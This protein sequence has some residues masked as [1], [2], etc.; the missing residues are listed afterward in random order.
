MCVCVW[1]DLWP[2]KK[3]SR[4]LSLYAA[5]LQV[6][7]AILL[8]YVILKEDQGPIAL[9]TAITLFILLILLVTLLVYGIWKQHKKILKSYFVLYAIVGLCCIIFLILNAFHLIDWRDS[10][11]KHVCWLAYLLATSFTGIYA[12]S[13]GVL[14]FYITFI[15][16]EE[17]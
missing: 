12:F 1:D 14:C 10:N 15:N 6:L 4:W 17:L 2:S 16:D 7:V 13:L 8:I 9:G 11:G 3:I 5:L